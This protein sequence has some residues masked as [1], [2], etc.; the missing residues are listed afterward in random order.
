M[1]RFCTHIFPL[2]VSAAVWGRPNRTLRS[3]PTSWHS[4]RPLNVCTISCY[5]RPNP[6]FTLLHWSTSLTLVKGAVLGME[7]SEMGIGRSE[8]GQGGV[9][10]E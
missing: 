8:V 5:I 3:V 9:R 1:H 10:Y 7:E 2:C 6:L 4:I